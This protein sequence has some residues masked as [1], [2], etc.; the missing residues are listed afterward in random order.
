MAGTARKSAKV[1]IS[2]HFFK[3]V[4]WGGTNCATSYCPVAYPE[5]YMTIMRHEDMVSPASTEDQFSIAYDFRTTNRYMAAAGVR[6]AILFL[7]LCLLVVI[8]F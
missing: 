1:A 8:S 3:I 7:V 2:Q 4:R 6:I 5:G